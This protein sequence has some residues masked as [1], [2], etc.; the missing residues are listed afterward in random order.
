[1]KWESYPRMLCAITGM[2]KSFFF[3]SSWWWTVELSESFCCFASACSFNCVF[4]F[5]FLYCNCKLHLEHTSPEIFQ[6]CDNDALLLFSSSGQTGFCNLD[7]WWN[8]YTR[9]SLDPSVAACPCQCRV[10][11]TDDLLFGINV[12]VKVWHYVGTWINIGRKI[13]S[14]N[15]DTLRQQKPEGTCSLAVFLSS[16]GWRNASKSTYK[17]YGTGNSFLVS[18]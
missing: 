17:T 13:S 2:K 14:S 3:S 8:F 11:F 12:L 4:C 15:F 6:W 1:M 7:I 18:L 16:D 10:F 5:P 9:L